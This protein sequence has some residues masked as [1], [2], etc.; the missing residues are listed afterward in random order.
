M[1]TCCDFITELPGLSQDMCPSG[2]LRVPV[3]GQVLVSKPHTVQKFV[4]KK[5]HANDF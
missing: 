5:V 3:Q 2:H 1:L 4:P